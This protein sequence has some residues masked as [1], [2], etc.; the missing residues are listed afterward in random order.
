M[1]TE[2]SDYYFD[3]IG[4]S[5][6]P[7]TTITWVNEA[8]A[9]SATAYAEGTGGAS[10]TRIPPDAEPWNSDTLSAEG[11]TFEHSFEIQ[12]TYDYFCIPHKT[13][14]MVGRLVV[15]DPGGVQGD[16]PDGPVPSPQRIVEDGAVGW[17]E[18]QSE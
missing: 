14:G 5:V 8:G 11:A 15:G 7:G 17:A 18:F 13:L 1:V 9:H 6:E 12:A 3:P 10:V 4:L 16:P 2:G